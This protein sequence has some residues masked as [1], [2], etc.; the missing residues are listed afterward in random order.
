MNSLKKFEELKEQI[1]NCS[2]CGLC[3]SVCPVFELTKN[4]CTALRGKNILLNQIFENN[5]KISK[6]QKKYI[7]MCTNCGKCFDYCPSKIDIIKINKIFNRPSLF[8]SILYKIFVIILQFFYKTDLKK[9]KLSKK[10]KIAYVKPYSQKNIPEYIKKWDYTVFDNLNCSFD[11]IIKYPKFSKIISKS[12][13]EK[14]SKSNFDYIFTNDVICK[15]AL[16][17]EIKC[18]QKI[19]YLDENTKNI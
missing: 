4:D 18:S 15:F 3:L 14:I 5:N 19:I 6:L 11:F 1:N 8:L 7:E 2:R 10:S 12:L 17:K 13:A 9:I 16:D